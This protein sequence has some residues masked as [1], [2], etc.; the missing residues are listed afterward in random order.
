MIRFMVTVYSYTVDGTKVV[1]D[2][3]ADEIETIEGYEEIR[4]IFY[5]EYTKRNVKVSRIC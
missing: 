1:V 3:F 4:Q 2:C 5:E